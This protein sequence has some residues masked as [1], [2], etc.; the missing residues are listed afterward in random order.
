MA[1]MDDAKYR[2]VIRSEIKDA[3][4]YAGGDLAIDREKALD[5]YMQEPFGNEVDGRSAVVTPDVRDAVEW[6]LPS[7]LKVFTASP[8]A[9]EFEPVGKE[10]EDAAKQATDYAN[11]VFYVDNDGFMILYT[12]FKDAFI[13]RDGYTKTWW[14]VE[15]K[16]KKTRH[17]GLSVDQVQALLEPTEDGEEVE[18]AEQREYTQIVIDEMGMP[19]EMPAYDVKIKRTRQEGRI[20]IENVPPE[21]MLFSRN[22]RTLDSL[23]LTGHRKTMTVQEWERD[24]GFDRDRLIKVSGNARSEVSYNRRRRANASDFGGRTGE[25]P[26]DDLRE[27]TLNHLFIR[28]DQDGDGVPEMRAIWCDSQVQE[29]FE[30]DE[31]EDH[32]FDM[33]CAIPMPHQLVGLGLADLS[34]DWQLIHSTLMRQGL[35]NIYQM[36]NARTLV[37]NKVNLDDYL[38]NRVGGYVRVDSDGADVGMHAT[39]MV[40]SDVG[41]FVYPMLERVE[42]LKEASTGVVRMNQGV[43]TDALRTDT[44]KGIA[45]MQGAGNQRLELMARIFAQTFVRSLFRRMLRLMVNHQD[46]PRMIRLRNDW[47]EIDPREWNSEMDLK[48]NVGLG[49][50]NKEQE[51]IMAAQV[52]TTTQGIIAMQGGL[53]GPLVTAKHAYNAVKGAYE[54]WGEH[55][56][57][58]LV[59]DPDSPEAQ[60]LAQQA[61]QK[62]D[63]ELVKI[64]EE[65]KAKVAIAEMQTQADAQA[66]QMKM[67]GDMQAAQMKAANDMQIERYKADLQ[68]Q[69]EREKAQLD[70]QTKLQ[71]AQINA[72]A[73][74]EQARLNPPQPR[75]KQE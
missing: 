13:Q 14:H 10:D 58:D 11:H 31:V 6:A 44:A 28:V 43:D 49:Y 50:D 63:P 20:R 3:E 4:T 55:N 34:G 39:P 1:A 32:P 5:L 75:G 64:Q 52:L 29:I 47:V 67:Q 57:E 73:A 16:V 12:A 19:A 66:D 62:P 59:M 8:K 27:V 25:A 33:A 17:T 61:A 40:T 74:T 48:V 37:S 9:V 45:M 46:K 68:M 21:E 30:D 41:G 51:A 72:Q 26:I 36:N 70:A 22:G 38:T 60:Q 69:L 71:I 15:P 7:I 18:I 65:G 23:T 56:P 42:M 2:A 24:F 53:S 54:A 35:D